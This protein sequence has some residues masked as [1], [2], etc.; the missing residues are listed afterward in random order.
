MS[1]AREPRRLLSRLRSKRVVRAGQASGASDRGRTREGQP[2]TTT[3]LV[4]PATLAVGIVGA[5]TASLL[6]LGSCATE[7]E[8]APSDART[9]AVAQDGALADAA[10]PDTPII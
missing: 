7:G 8:P 4:I 6:A 9:D 5:S 3:R 1:R 10:M 2:Q